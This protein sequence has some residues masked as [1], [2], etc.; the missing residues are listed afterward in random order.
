MESS[1]DAPKVAF[2]TRPRAPMGVEPTGAAGRNA[3]LTYSA[4]HPPCGAVDVLAC[5]DRGVLHSDRRKRQPR[6]G[7]REP[8]GVGL[9]DYEFGPSPAELE[10]FTL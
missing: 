6:V 2:A 10:R 9:D 1:V 3:Q 7:S 5:R 4:K 8:E